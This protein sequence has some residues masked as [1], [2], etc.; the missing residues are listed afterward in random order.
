VRA[1]QVVAPGQV[2]FLDV[3][4]PALKPG[5]ALVRPLLISLCGSDVHLL[6]TAARNTYPLPV[7][8]T[9][10]EIVAAVEEV[11]APGS[12]IRPGDVALTLVPSSTGMCERFLAP[13]EDVLL[14]PDIGRLDHLLMAQQLGTVIYAGKRLPNIAGKRVVVIGQGSAGLF[15][16]WMC[17]RMGAARVIGLDVKEARVVAGLKFG[18]THAINSAHVEAVEAIEEITGGDLADL[19]VEAVGQPETIDLAVR[20]VKR[21]GTILFFGV[22]RADSFEFD[23]GAFFQKCCTSITCVGSALEPGRMSTRLALELIARGEVD[24]S[25]MLTH[26]LPFDRLLQ[27][28][29]LATTRDDGAIKVVVEMPGYG[30]GDDRG[31]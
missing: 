22:P 11:D 5:H 27:A 24:V 23:F 8:T 28:Y 6:H 30:N 18:A 15:F 4:V 3:P 20:L 25:P 26:R 12:G 10:H 1:T 29:E 16:D 21:W 17:R 19:V 31:E 2:V 7:G 9:G 13:V 14:L